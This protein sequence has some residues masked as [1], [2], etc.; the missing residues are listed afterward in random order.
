MPTLTTKRLI[1][2]EWTAADRE[3]F[4]RINADRRVME[5]LGEP[6]AREQSDQLADRIEAH[7]RKH[8]FSL[9]AAELAETREFI[10]FIGIAVPPFEAAFTP[11]VE[12]GWRLAAEHWG[13]GLATEGAREILRYAFEELKL[14][15]L[16]SMTAAG[17]E[18]SRRVMEK[19]GMRRDP[20]DDFDHPHVPEGHALRPHVLYRLSRTQWIERARSIDQRS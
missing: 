6:L 7:Y 11:C 14:A 3:A 5:F 1:L 2:R 16:V 10:G 17:N 15:D 19:I 18:R 9:C 12:I 13:K 8:G 20:V 4:A